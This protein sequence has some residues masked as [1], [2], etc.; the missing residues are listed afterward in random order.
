M[1]IMT[2]GVEKLAPI[3]QRLT[4]D[5]L[6]LIRRIGQRLRNV[7]IDAPFEPEQ[8][9]RFD[10]L[11]ILSS[12]VDRTARDLA[13]ERRLA[14]ERQA[15]L[16]QAKEEAEAR[17]HELEQRLSEL[18]A[19]YAAQ[20]RLLE[21]VRELSTPVLQIYQGVLLMP[22][23]G[24][25]DTRRISD[26]QDDLLTALSATRAQVVIID[27]TGV[28]AIDTQVADGLVRSA[29][30][31]RLLGATVLLCGLSPEVA[32]VV[33]SLGIDLRVLETFPDL[34]VAMERALRLVDVQIVRQQ[35]NP[36]QTRPPAFAR[37]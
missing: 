28:T 29:S 26:M 7:I 35:A 31:A 19:A 22:L 33:V 8:Q 32:Q 9:L 6:G 1:A 25:V 5:E 23:I 12:M 10:E 2:N 37:R 20:E 15:E 3:A 21:L 13:Q 11:G 18:S 16:E 14:R 36:K 34:R 27:I 24:S 4:D 17:G 30:S